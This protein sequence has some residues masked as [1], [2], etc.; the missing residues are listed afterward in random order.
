MRVFWI[1]TAIP[2]PSGEG[3]SALEYELI[4]ALAPRHEIHVLTTM[5]EHPLGPAELLATG[6]RLT[7]VEAQV[8]PHPTSK[9]GVAR[10]LVRADPN[11]TVWLGR[12]R[13]RAFRE[14]VLKAAG[15]E[16]PP[17]VV[18]IRDGDLAPVVEGL[19]FT[20]GLLLFDAL[21]RALDNRRAIEP[22]A[23]RRLQLTVESARTRR[24]ERR[25]YRRATGL[26]SVSEVDAA[27]LRAQTG[28]EVT[29]VEIPIGAHYFE[30][31]TVARSPEVVAFVGS[32]THRP[33]VDAIHWL[34]NVIWPLVVAR[35]PSAQLVVAGRSDPGG[36]AAATLR[37][38]VEAAGGELR[39]D[40]EDIR[41]VY[42]EAAVAVAPLRS[43]SGLRNK[44]L[45]AM[46]C[47]A[48]LVSTPAAVEG[49]PELVARYVNVTPAND[50]SAFADEVVAVLDD[51]GAP[52]RAAAAIADL[53]P[54]RTAAIA[55]RHER[56]WTDLAAAEPGAA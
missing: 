1:T 13:I 5:R 30:P 41:P 39:V 20:T 50:A 17:D 19:P 14:A 28:C 44:V 12:D 54:L 29:T 16:G 6:A 3:A 10:V 42:W 15:H 37:P 23:R 38:V 36:A 56:W 27:W 48:P 11:V 33:N 32:L 25:W 53:A 43:G 52:S 26:L 45:H 2:H 55:A 8:Q 47:G 46:A 40:L 51:P 18:L 7:T 31:P 49:I 22:L 35:R 34:T 24:F 21:T 9:V 4:A